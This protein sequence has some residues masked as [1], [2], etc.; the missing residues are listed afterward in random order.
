MLESPKHPLGEVSEGK[1]NLEKLSPEL[2]ALVL[3][4]ISSI[5][6]L[7]SIIR[8]S[9]QYYQ[10][11]RDL[12]E[13]VLSA[14]LHRSLLP[15][16]LSDALFTI[17]ASCSNIRGSNRE[18]IL[19]FIGRFK[20][21]PIP[22]PTTKTIPLPTSISLCQ[23]HHTVDFFVRDF[24]RNITTAM[25]HCCLS[26]GL[27][28]ESATTPVSRAGHLPLSTVEEGRIQRAFYHLELYA[29]LFFIKPNENEELSAVEQARLFLAEFP[30]WQ[31]DELACV[32]D[33]LL[34]RLGAVFDEVENDFVAKELGKVPKDGDSK[35]ATE[36]AEGINDA[37][38]INKEESKEPAV[39]GEE[40]WEHGEDDDDNDDDSPDGVYPDRW[41]I[42]D[43]FFSQSGKLSYHRPYMQYM[44]SL[45]LPFLRQL[46]EANG[47]ERTRLVLA[48]AKF[49]GDFLSDALEVPREQT[50]ATDQES[51]D[52]FLGVK[53][54]FCGDNLGEPNEGWLWS[55][56]FS[57][58]SRSNDR[59]HGRMREWGYVF[60]DSTRL[61]SS[62]IL[63]FR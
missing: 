45:G 4:Q 62:G 10:V 59:H 35:C 23:L 37:V 33:Y 32:S 53:L 48:H 39:N 34:R 40:D 29:H 18:S 20:T 46:L 42:A 12:K 41:E 52:S 7:Y 22:S 9:P 30:S 1:N 63:N 51:I 49:G 50:A 47:E 54:E 36:V 25:D 14:V 31:I 21:D 3:V 2:Q 16:V 15:E 44:I 24:S 27:T 56:S 13:R 19:C 38:G 5:Q 6:T 28:Q 8:A 26:L 58:S 55:N 57:P 43:V 11:F 17:E 60:W 61:R